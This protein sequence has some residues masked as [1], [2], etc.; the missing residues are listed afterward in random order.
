MI[1]LDEND[2]ITGEETSKENVERMPNCM[3]DLYELASYVP[4]QIIEGRIEEDTLIV[5]AGQSG[6][7]KTYLIMSM[8]VAIATGKDWLGR[9]TTKVNVGFLNYEMGKRGWA[10]RL[11]K[12]LKGKRLTHADIYTE[13]NNGMDLMKPEG[14]VE[15]KMLINLRQ[16]GVIFI[17]ALSGIHLGDENKTQDMTVVMNALLEA[18]QETHCAIVVLHHTKKD[19]NG[20]RGSG[21]IL[22]KPDVLL[23]LETYKQ[24]P[25]VKLWSV[26][27]RDD[28]DYVMYATHKFNKE[29][30]DYDIMLIEGKEDEKPET[31]SQ[32]ASSIIKAYIPA[33][34]PGETMKTGEIVALVRSIDP[35]LSES[36]VKD[37]IKLAVKAKKLVSNSYGVYIVQ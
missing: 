33:S 34:Q 27:N 24:K 28:E 13:H 15:L 29:E 5:I 16:L 32:K 9:K 37:G 26:K 21:L 17:D 4:K 35:Q 30:G 20:Y 19:G 36:T 10:R 18:A 31:K 8:A 6:T 25:D 22:N 1:T 23:E 3:D 14:L 11:V 7:G 12:V 2:V